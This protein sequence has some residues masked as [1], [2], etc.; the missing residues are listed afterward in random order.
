MEDFT[1]LVSVVGYCAH[2]EVFRSSTNGVGKSCLCCRFIHPGVDDYVPDHPSLLALHE[3][4]SGV[5]CTD[6]FLYWGPKELEF[7]NALKGKGA[8][9]KFEVLE[10]TLF[11]QDETSHVFKR[12][13]SLANPENYAK[14]LLKP[15]H[16]SRKISYYSRDTI[17]F[18]ERYK[19]LPYPTNVDRIPRGFIVVVDVSWYG[20]K[21]EEQLTAIESIIYKIR[22][23]TLVIAATKRDQCSSESLRRLTEW[24]NKHR[25]TVVE[26]SS[27]ENINIESV[28]RV[29]ASKVLKKAKISEECVDYSSATGM[30]LHYTTNVKKQFKS[31]L[32]KQ[33]GTSNVP[34]VKIEKAAE[35]LKAVDVLGKFGAD[36]I[37]ARYLLEVRDR[38]VR[39]YVGVSENPDMRMEMLE[40]FVDDDLMVDLAAHKRVLRS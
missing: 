23:A 14:Q 7:P 36:E 31:Y 10:H 34:L 28:F 26:T 21:F 19:C 8:K 40:Q 1:C 9:V 4:E 27:K 39:Q 24:A 20:Q 22:N 38:E 3:F 25:I 11:Y 2:V 33:V 5:V 16:S 32:N 35:Y 30:L 17:G 15:P 6:S 29:I 18:P 13:K 12:Y 37:F